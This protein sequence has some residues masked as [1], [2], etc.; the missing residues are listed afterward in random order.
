MKGLK[1][2]NTTYSVEEGQEEFMFPVLDRLEIQY[3]SRLRLKPCPPAFRECHIY[4]SD[5]V[6]TVLPLVQPSNW[7]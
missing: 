4:E 6:I 5:Q 2:W 3:C 1:E 7:I